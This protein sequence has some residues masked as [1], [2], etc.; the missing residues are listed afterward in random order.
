ML[1]RGHDDSSS[2][3]QIGALCHGGHARDRHAQ[4]IRVP[5]AC[6]SAGTRGLPANGKKSRGRHTD[7]QRLP[8]IGR[9]SRISTAR[10][11]EKLIQHFVSSQN[12]A[13]RMARDRPCG[14]HQKCHEL[15]LSTNSSE[16][17]HRTTKLLYVCKREGLC[18]NGYER[19]YES[20]P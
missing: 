13:A 15:G 17:T 3:L 6:I 2:Q 1:E 16:P 11:V 7:C 20:S 8:K 5:S 12:A 18:R 19:C 4:P 14:T 9:T 10:F